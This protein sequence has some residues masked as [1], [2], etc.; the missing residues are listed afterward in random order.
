MF[1]CII[2]G[3]SHFKELCPMCS[4]IKFEYVELI[5]TYSK[6]CFCGKR[7]FIKYQGSG[8]CEIRIKCDNCDSFVIFNGF[9]LNKIQ[10]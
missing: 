8:S 3:W 9:G 2:H 4:E 7:Y 1:S 10:V 5:E 6:Y